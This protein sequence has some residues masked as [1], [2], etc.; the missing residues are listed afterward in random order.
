[1]E[2]SGLRPESLSDYDGTDSLRLSDIKD[3][4]ISDEIDLDNVPAVVMVKSKLSKA[5]HQYFSSLG[6]DG[7]TYIKEYLEER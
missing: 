7:T 2:F 4:R 1:M 5:R 6:E 3:L